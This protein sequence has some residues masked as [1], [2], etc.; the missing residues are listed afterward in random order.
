MSIRPRSTPAPSASD[1]LR[2]H[3]RRPTTSVGLMSRS[4]FV[5]TDDAGEARRHADTLEEPTATGKPSRIASFARRSLWS[6]RC[7]SHGNAPSRLRALERGLARRRDRNRGVTAGRAVPPAGRADHAFARLVEGV[8][9]VDPL[10]R[11]P[12]SVVGMLGEPRAIRRTPGGGG[13]VDRGVEDRG[14]SDDFAA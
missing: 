1:S 7:P 2:A 13:P 8:G 6:T 5:L 14:I 11:P 10:V 4:S 9:K 12:R 3:Q